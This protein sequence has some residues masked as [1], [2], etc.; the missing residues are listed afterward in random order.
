MDISNMTSTRALRSAVSAVV[1]VVALFAG[2]LVTPAGAQAPPTGTA[3]VRCF[4]EGTSV[5]VVTLTEPAVGWRLRFLIDGVE[6]NTLTGGEA[7]YWVLPPGNGTFDL[8][9]TAE[10]IDEVPV[11]VLSTEITIDCAIESTTTVVPP[12][13]STGPPVTTAP[14]VA[15]RSA[16]R[17][18]SFTG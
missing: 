12:P 4:P 3:E 13:P 1:A 17:G 11:E 16:A 14:Q 15:D 6:A 9:V 7:T 10:T 8:V 2:V 5:V 18:L